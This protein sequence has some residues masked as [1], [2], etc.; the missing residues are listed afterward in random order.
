MR[1]IFLLGLVA[2]LSACVNPYS[3]FY[4]AA[5]GMEDV[6]TNP[7]YDA[8]PVAVQ[9]FSSDDFDRDIKAMVRR[10]YQPFGGASFNAG[11]DL[12][13]RENLLKQA[14]KVGAHAVLVKSDYSHTVSGA[15]P[16]VVPQ[17]STTYTSGSATAYGPGGS[18]TAYGSATST[19]YGSQTVMMPYSVRRFDAGAVFFAKWK[20][21]VGVQVA[22]VPDAVRKARAS[23]Q[24][25][26]ID[27]VIE[28][29][30]AYRA[31]VMEGDL[32]L[33][34]NGAKIFSREDFVENI[35]GNGSSTMRLELVRDGKTKV[36]T[37]SL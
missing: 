28:G 3:E 23:N 10:G 17:T 22:Q 9:I 19:T 24:G 13:T 29:S 25:V 36:L 8:T 34:I 7:S 15:V 26:M 35:S 32:L 30:P 33:S 12:I 14:E 2:F 4:V 6:R 1:K 37:V 31:G 18:A 11:E 21:R 5:P 20:F 16:I 27:V